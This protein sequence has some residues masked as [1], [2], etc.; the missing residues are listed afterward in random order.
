MTMNQDIE[1]VDYA[2]SELAY[3]RFMAQA[4][5]EATAT[6]DLAAASHGM[7]AG[8]GPGGLLP[9]LV[10]ATGGSGRITAVDVSLPHLD[11][12]LDLVTRHGVQDRIE[13]RQADLQ[14]KL[15]FADDSFDWVW[16]ADVLWPARFPDPGAVISEFR[17]VVR[18]GGLIALYYGDFYRG[19]TMPGQPHLEHAIQRASSRRWM[20]TGSE[21]THQEHAARWLRLAGLEDIRRTCHMVQCHAPLDQDQRAYLQQYFA[22]EYG[23]VTFAE[24]AAVGVSKHAWQDWLSRLDPASADYVLDD[25]DY[26]CIQIATLTTAQVAP[27][28]GSDPGKRLDR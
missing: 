22:I 11:H 25:P 20:G 3:N 24:V 8:C 1:Q 10:A 5:R 6:L 23:P 15:P 13:L 4:Y 26:Y 19:L 9:L 17:R 21:R 14:G 16:C 28:P 7:D 18:P 2:D 12:A 27:G